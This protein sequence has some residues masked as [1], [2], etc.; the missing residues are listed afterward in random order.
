MLAALA[1]PTYAP[2]L[3]RAN[4]DLR[5]AIWEALDNRQPILLRDYQ[6]QVRDRVLV[7][8]DK[9]K[10]TLAS[11]A[12]GTG[13]TEVLLGVLQAELEAGN[14]SRALILAHTRELISQPVI[15]M[16]R[17]WP[18]LPCP[19]IVMSSLNMPDAQIV[20]ATVQTLS[21]RGCQRLDEI[22]SHG[23][24]SHLVIDETHRATARTYGEVVDR[25]KTAN[26]D[27]RILGVTATPKRSDGEGLGKLFQSVAATI[28]ITDAVKMGALCPYVGMKA[29][30]D[31][32]LSDVPATRDGWS[33][34][35][36]GDVM[37]AANALDIV[38]Q[39][40]QVAA[41]R[42]PAKMMA[43]GLNQG[44]GVPQGCD[45]PVT[46]RATIAF[47]ASV[48]HAHRLADAFSAV[49]VKA[50]AIDGTTKAKERWAILED[51]KAGRIQVV[52]NFGVLVEG[53][54]APHTECLLMARPVR[55]SL[56][57][58]QMAGR[59]LRTAEGKTE[60]LIID[61]LPHDT[62]SMITS[63]DLLGKPKKQKKG[64]KR[65]EELGIVL[66]VFGID[67]SEFGVDADPATVLLKIMDFFGSGAMR[68]L[69]WTVDGAVGSVSTGARQALVMLLPQRQRVENAEQWRGSG[70][71]SPLWEAEYQFIKRHHLYVLEENKYLSH[72][73]STDSEQEAYET[74]ERWVDDHAEGWA[75]SRGKQ[76]R[77]RPATLKR[78]EYARSL[79]VWRDGMTDGQASQAITHELALRALH[80]NKLVR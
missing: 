10:A 20:V 56:P 61:F 18:G 17:G 74:A 72:I 39:K 26:P 25:L 19:G 54:D 47:T 42:D 14:L 33:D 69:A 48:K 36:L 49:G 80:K 22:L 3:E 77:N 75:S 43:A 53:F 76:W 57:Y 71:W 1:Q 68:K 46:H 45:W 58:T 8:F 66:D 13:K 28:K 60:C 52:C 27:L 73:L 15:R 59:G 41:W 6:I 2:L 37:S 38:V 79:G 70:R 24:I 65:L 51:Y 7:E 31:V 9:G 62:P 4:D 32:S 78:E 30:I 44:T 35:L 64:E 29:Q 16:V 50:A 63:G 34:E 55:S 11:L 40:W 12:T 5:E 67:A 21:A 23:P